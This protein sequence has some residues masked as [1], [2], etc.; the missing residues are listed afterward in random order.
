LGFGRVSSSS[1]GG[2]S[3]RAGRRLVRAASEA[4]DSA[5]RARRRERWVYVF[6]E[7]FMLVDLVVFH[8]VSPVSERAAY[9]F[10]RNTRRILPC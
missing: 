5:F 7:G 8:E 6:K 3:A 2:S 1:G 9:H 10:L 4:S